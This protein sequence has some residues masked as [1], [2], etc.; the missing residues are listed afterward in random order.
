MRVLAATTLVVGVGSSHAQA[1]GAAA[2]LEIAPEW[3]MPIGSITTHT[4]WSKRGIYAFFAS[5]TAREVLHR[6]GLSV[7][8]D[9]LVYVGQTKSS[10]QQRLSSHLSGS[11]NL[12]WSLRSVL[13]HVGAD[14]SHTDV[15]RFMRRNLTVAMLPVDNAA[16]ID[17]F[18]GRLIQDRT[19]TLN[20]AGV[21]NA[22]AKRL[23]QLRSALAA[24]SGS[25]TGAVIRTRLRT[26]ARGAWLG[27]LVE[28][29]VTATVEYLHV[30]NGRKTPREAILAGAKTVGMVAGVGALAAGAASAAAS[31]G[32]TISAPVVIPAAVVGGGLYAWGAGDRIL[33]ALDEDTRRD[34]EARVAASATAVE[35]GFAAAV[36]AVEDGL[37]TA[38]AAVGW[39]N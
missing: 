36:E 23:K 20:R 19:P 37:A 22:N 11:S 26:L 5:D 28:L 12:R 32:I 27:G 14:V 29:P 25:S 35:E 2:A 31:A 21:D 1:Q 38:A 17:A 13:S 8:D 4:S 34:I 33:N 15:S 7:G 10:F 6:A 30:R 3:A 18:E 9:G 16:A 24:T 39:D